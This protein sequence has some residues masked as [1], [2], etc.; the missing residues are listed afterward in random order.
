MVLEILKCIPARPVKCEAHFS[1]VV[2]IIA[3]LDLEK[4]SHSQTASFVVFQN[5]VVCIRLQIETPKT[6]RSWTFHLN[7]VTRHIGK[8]PKNYANV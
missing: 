5:P 2:I 7:H 6:A 4:I 3:F 1:G 8:C